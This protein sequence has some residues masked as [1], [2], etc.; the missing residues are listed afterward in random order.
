M[1]YLSQHCPYVLATPLPPVQVHLPLTSSLGVQHL[2][3]SRTEIIPIHARHN[4]LL[5][6]GPPCV[7]RP[8][9]ADALFDISTGM[10]PSTAARSTYLTPDRPDHFPPNPIPTQ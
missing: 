6:P 8:G 9:T 2:T 4:P 5:H 1:T 3:H 10:S 7:V